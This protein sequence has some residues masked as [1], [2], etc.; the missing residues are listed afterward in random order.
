M[1]TTDYLGKVANEMT[2]TIVTFTQHVEQKRLHIVVQRFMVQIHFRQETEILTIDR[3]LPPINLENRNLSISI[4]FVAGRMFYRTF[5]LT[6][7]I[8]I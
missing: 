5:Q 2:A 6:S 7:V 1:E 8:R 3:I 4:Y